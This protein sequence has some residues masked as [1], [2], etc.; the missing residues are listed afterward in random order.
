MNRVVGCQD[1]K[2]AFLEHKVSYKF[3]DAEQ[4]KPNG[5]QVLAVGKPV[6]TM[7]PELGKPAHTAQEPQQQPVLH[8]MELEQVLPQRLEPIQLGR[9]LRQQWEPIRSE[10]VL[11]NMK[12]PE[13]L[14]QLGNK[15]GQE[16][17]QRK[18][19]QDCKN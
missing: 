3:V 12:E 5:K 8:N 1:C 4:G 17:V 10:L 14:Q 16:L 19:V 2:S 6:H 9:V 7:V 13:P 11:H 15:M 18:R